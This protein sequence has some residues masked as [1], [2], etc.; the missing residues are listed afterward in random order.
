RPGVL[1]KAQITSLLNNDKIENGIPENAGKSSIDLHIG[2][3]GFA[4]QGSIKPRQI[5]EIA[6]ITDSFKENDPD[7]QNGDTFHLKRGET[8]VFKIK[9]SIRFNNTEFSGLATGRSSIGR[10]DV[11][12][13]LLTDGSAT[14]DRVEKGYQ[15]SLWIEVT[16]LSFPIIIKRGMSLNQL[17]VF[18]G[19]PSL[20]RI[21]DQALH[22]WGDR[23][24]LDES[25]N[26][27]PAV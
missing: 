25:G 7:F 10:L 6:D 12:T 14:Y 2:N 20:C 27:V 21:E 26:P 15:G 24:L 4:M 23:L 3:T 1:N 16:P 11:L 9:E 19:D 13:R 22:L 18:K 8:Y 5:N 17:R